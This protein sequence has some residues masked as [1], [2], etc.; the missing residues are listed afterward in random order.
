MAAVIDAFGWAADELI[1][2]ETT[3]QVLER[4]ID[5]KSQRCNIEKIFK[6]QQVS[7]EAMDRLKQL[8]TDCDNY[9]TLYDL[10]GAFKD[11]AFSGLKVPFFMLEEPSIIPHIRPR[12]YSISADPFENGKTFTKTLKFVFGETRLPKKDSLGF[13]TEFL[14]SAEHM[15]TV[16]IK[17]QFAP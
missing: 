2:N 13:C 6:G 3:A 16:E 17:T 5:L 8:E 7:A 15:N 4:V 12:Y 14:T 9:T 1:G 11:P 10:A